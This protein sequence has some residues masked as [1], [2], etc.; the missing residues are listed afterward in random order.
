MG[1]ILS[2]HKI[3]KSFGG[4]T[5]L[6]DV[7]FD[8][9]EGEIHGIVGENGAGKSALM[10]IIAG[11]YRLDSGE[12]EFNGEPVKFKSPTDSLN[13]GIAIIYQEFNLVKSLSIAENI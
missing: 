13:C 11:D 5:V 3:C 7:E 8:L 10:K 9:R 12:L 2:A 1:S 6:K 4:V